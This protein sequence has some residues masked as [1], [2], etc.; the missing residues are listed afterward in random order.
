MSKQ[1]LVINGHPHADGEHLCHTLADSY[2]QA[3]RGAG[4]DVRQ[5]AVAKIDFPLLRDPEDFEHGTPPAVIA[6]VQ[7]EVRWAEHLVLVFP[8]WLGTMPALLK[9]LLEQVF[10]PGFAMERRDTGWPRQLLKG[11]S[12]R[13]IITMGMPAF[14]YRWFYWSHALRNLER[15]ILKFVGMSPVRHTLIGGIGPTGKQAEAKIETWIR[16]IQELGRSGF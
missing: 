2:V 13:V 15:N 12:A 6:D 1:I 8:L 14:V 4:H 9:G 5:L 7:G 16:K 10:R 3:A 11:K